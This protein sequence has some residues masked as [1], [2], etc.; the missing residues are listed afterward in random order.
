[1]VWYTYVRDWKSWLNFYLF[2]QKKTL[3]CRNGISLNYADFRLNV[4]LKICLYVKSL[5][6]FIQN[7]SSMIF[8]MPCVKNLTKF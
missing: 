1:M 2:T 5:L 7:N 6:I 8:F 4:L 3:S